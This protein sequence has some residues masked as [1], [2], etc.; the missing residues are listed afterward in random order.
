MIA[1]DIPKIP[2]ANPCKAVVTK[3]LRAEQSGCGLFFLKIAQ[4]PLGY[5][6]HHWV[7]EQLQP[8]FW[9]IV[10]WPKNFKVVVT[11]FSEITAICGSSGDLAVSQG[12]L[13]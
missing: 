13:L 4:L 5:C 1:C 3:H 8:L 12:I 2:V 11:I 10:W 6:S 7:T 9:P